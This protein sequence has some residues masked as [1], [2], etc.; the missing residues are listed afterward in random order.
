MKSLHPGIISHTSL[1]ASS[2]ASGPAAVKCKVV[3][4][5][6]EA[7]GFLQPGEEG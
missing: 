1:S 3:Q 5:G 4:R 2:S 6:A 7:T